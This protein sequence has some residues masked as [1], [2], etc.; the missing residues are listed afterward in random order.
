MASRSVGLEHIEPEL[1]DYIDSLPQGAIFYDI[2]ASTGIYS[3]YAK[4]YGLNVYAFEPEAQNFSLL[5]KIT[6]RI[7]QLHMQAFQP[8]ISP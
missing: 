8:S 5:E 2:G 1:L 7:Y 4:N 3:V 6:T